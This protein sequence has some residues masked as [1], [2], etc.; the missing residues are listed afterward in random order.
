[1][2]SG[3]KSHTFTFFRA[4]V[5]AMVHSPIYRR[6][7][8]ALNPTPYLIQFFSRPFVAKIRN[9]QKSSQPITKTQQR[10]ARARQ[11]GAAPLHLQSTLHGH[12]RDSWVRTPWRRGGVCPPDPPDPP[13]QRSLHP[14]TGLWRIFSGFRIQDA[15]PPPFSGSPMRVFK[16]GT[17]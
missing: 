13:A 1:M 2:Q 7:H 16:S 12:A 5:G 6:V 8:L 3:C 11:E 4:K 10:P 9:T 15:G 14:A 17:S